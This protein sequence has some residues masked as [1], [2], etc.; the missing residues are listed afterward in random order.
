MLK[1]SGRGFAWI[2][3]SE[4]FGQQTLHNAVHTNHLLCII[5]HFI[6]HTCLLSACHLESLV[7][8]THQHL[9]LL[10]LQLLLLVLHA[11]A[12]RLAHTCKA[13]ACCAWYQVLTQTN[14]GMLTV[15]HTCTLIQAPARA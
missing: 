4:C 11:S 6:R 13:A 5:Y 10:L 1:A 3:A 2:G 14:H 12:Y 9:L 7:T 15:Y 8:V